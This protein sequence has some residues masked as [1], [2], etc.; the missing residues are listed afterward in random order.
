MFRL[1]IS[2][3]IRR[4]Y[5]NTLIKLNC[6]TNHKLKLYKNN[7]VST[8]VKKTVISF[9]FYIFTIFLTVISFTFHIFVIL[10]D[11]SQDSWLKHVLHM[12]NKWMSE[13]LWCRISWI[14]TEDINLI[15]MTEWSIY[16]HAAVSCT[17]QLT[18]FP[19]GLI[20]SLYV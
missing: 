2:A 6:A 13:Y 8:V 14:T 4:Y 10:L 11:D 19:G 1:S 17:M 20:Y 15:N 16:I 5:K 18:L 12:S 9:T 3:I 7:N